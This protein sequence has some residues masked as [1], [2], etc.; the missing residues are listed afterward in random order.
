MYVYLQLI[1]NENEKNSFFAKQETNVLFVCSLP[2]IRSS[3][4]MRLIGNG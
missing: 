4:T 1:S 3:I 2:F